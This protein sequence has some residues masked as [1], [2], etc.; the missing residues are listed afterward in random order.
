VE[1]P[2]SHAI[3]VIN[4]DEILWTSNVDSKVPHSPMGGGESIPC[5]FQSKQNFDRH[6]LR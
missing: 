1:L 5:D 3:V 2:N 6:M 4:L